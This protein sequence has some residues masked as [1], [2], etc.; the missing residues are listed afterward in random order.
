MRVGFVLQSAEIKPLFFD[1]FLLKKTFYNNK[2]RS[3][4]SYY[5]SCPFPAAP[6]PTC[7]FLFL[8]TTSTTSKHSYNLVMRRMMIPNIVPELSSQQELRFRDASRGTH[9][10]TTNLNHHFAH[11]G[12]V[13]I[14]ASINSNHQGGLLC[15]EFFC[16]LISR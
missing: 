9:K 2:Q 1:L 10:G 14:M 5:R 11:P 16:L 15:P 13:I 4:H 8:N 7:N 12:T 6:P 3:D